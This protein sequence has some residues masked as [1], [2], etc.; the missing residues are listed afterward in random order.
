MTKAVIKQLLISNHEY[1]RFPNLLKETNVQLYTQLKWWTREDR[2][3][4]IAHEC[5][6]WRG[7][8]NDTVD[9]I[10]VINNYEIKIACAHWK[11]IARNDFT[12]IIIR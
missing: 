11:K 5:V 9:V 7:L 2:N 12:Y 3:Q 1:F 6:C 8:V 4:A 10:S